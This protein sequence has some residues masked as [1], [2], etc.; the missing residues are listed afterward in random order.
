MREDAP[1]GDSP[2]GSRVQLQRFCQ[3]SLRFP[4][5]VLLCELF[6]SFC[7]TTQYTNKLLWRKII[8]DNG[9]KNCLLQGINVAETQGS[10]R[11]VLS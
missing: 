11:E 3:V 4:G 2:H 5:F 10:T 1:I 6:V 9:Q 7:H 8:L